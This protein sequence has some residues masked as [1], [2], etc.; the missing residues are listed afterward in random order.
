M[1]HELVVQAVAKAAC[2]VSTKK[3][4]LTAVLAVNAIQVFED[5]FV[6]RLHLD[7][8]ESGVVLHRKASRGV[9][10]GMDIQTDICYIFHSTSSL[11]VVIPALLWLAILV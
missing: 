2:L 8:G 3:V 5:V 6:V 1:A 11:Y 4:K 10:C 9:I 7:D